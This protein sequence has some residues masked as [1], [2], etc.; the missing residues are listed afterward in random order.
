MRAVPLGS[1][2]PPHP[3]CLDAPAASAGFNTLLRYHSPLIIS[4]ACNLEPLLGSLMGWLAGIVA[5]PGPW[6]WVGGALVL[7]STAT[8]SLASHR[9]EQR[10]ASRAVA[11]AA[12]QRILSGEGIEV[13]EAEASGGG[14]PGRSDSAADGAW[15]RA[16]LQEEDAAAGG[17]GGTSPQQRQPQ[18]GKLADGVR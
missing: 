13:A 18:A 17:G 3:L 9:R 5:L 10:Q 8:V 4:L 1:V 16:W 7:A 2:R 6:T 14:V 11:T 12:L 15:G